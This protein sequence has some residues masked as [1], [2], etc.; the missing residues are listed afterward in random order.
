ME[1][2][3]SKRKYK[4]AENAINASRTTSFRNKDMIFREGDIGEEMYEILLGKVG[5]YLH[6]GTKQQVKVAEKF[7][8]EFFGEVGITEKRPRTAT[9]IAEDPDGTTLLVVRSASGL[10]EYVKTHPENLEPI[11]DG[12]S[13]RYKNEKIRYIVCCETIAEY[14]KALESGGPIPEELQEKFD[15]YAGEPERVTNDF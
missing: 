1:F 13:N 9:C 8:G 2:D 12:M 11:L 3:F 15:Y 6:Y 14:K 10:V 4:M 7:P 5:I